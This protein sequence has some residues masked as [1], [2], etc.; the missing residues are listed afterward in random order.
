MPKP[1]P[2]IKI[3]DES[4]SFEELFEESL[5]VANPREGEVVQGKVIT[6]SDD[7]ITVD[8]GFKSEG[9]IAV[10]EFKGDVP[11]VGDVIEVYLDKIENDNG[12]MVLSREK[13]EVLKAWDEISKAVENDELVEGKIIAKVKGGLAVDI[14]VKAF[15][16]GSQ[17]DLRPVKYLEDFVGKVYQFKIIKFNKKRGNIVLSR[18]AL[19]ERERETMK[20]KTLEKLEEGMVITGTVKNITEYGAFIDLGGV[21]GLLHITDMSWG[22]VKHPGDILGL[23]DEVTVK[24]LKYDPERERVSLGLKQ[25]SPDPW[26]SVSSKYRIGDRVK[27]D[28]VSLTDYGAFVELEPG[29]EGLIHVSEMSWTKRVKHPS[30]VVNISDVVEAVVLDIDSK[31]HRIS[32]GMKQTEPNP[33]DLLAQKYPIGSKIKGQIKNVTDF[34]IFIGMEDGIDGM[35]H[36]SDVS[37]TEKVED[38]S[39]RFKKG[40]EVEALVLNIDQENQRFSLGIKQ[41]ER[42]PWED[43]EKRFP[44][45]QLVTSKVTKVTDFGV[46]LELEQGVEGFIHVSQLSTERIEHPNQIVKVGDEIQAGVSQIDRKERRITLSVKGMHVKEEREALKEYKKSQKSSKSSFGDIL[47]EKLAKTLKKGS[48]KGEDKKEDKDEE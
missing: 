8:I 31:N 21:D 3:A 32:L 4:K 34:G 46:F 25:I 45:G 40:D 35:V 12:F 33:W 18:R 30:K 44:V 37:W 43:I 1:L 15:L 17:V 27:G 26:D 19:L 36:I 22:R 23:G 9:Q 28:V 16:P 2:E 14:G 7:F 10:E 38:L 5:K 20:S 39:S 29:I 41:L 48:A 24:V 13:A 11:K 42:D 6:V 47:K